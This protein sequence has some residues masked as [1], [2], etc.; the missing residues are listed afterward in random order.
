MLNAIAALNTDDLKENAMQLGKDIVRYFSGFR[1]S[2]FGLT[3]VLASISLLTLQNT[4]AYA[5]P[6]YSRQT[7]LACSS[8]HYTPP[9]LNAFGRQ[10]KAG[11]YTFTTKAAISEDKKDHNAGLNI[12]ENFPLSVMFFTSLTSTNKTVPNN[13][14]SNFQFPQQ[15][16][17]FLAGKWAEHVGS[18]AQV[19]YSGASNNFNWDNTDVRIVGNDAKLLGKTLVYGLTFNNNPTVEDL[20]NSTP[21]WGYPFSG[22]N[23]TPKPAAT[24]IINGPLGQDV[25]GLGGYGLWN[26]HVYVAGTAY[27]SE[28][29]GGNQPNSGTGWTYNIH[30]VAP[31]WRVAW[32][33]ATDKSNVMV[34]TYGMHMRS[35]PNKVTGP[36]DDYTDWAAD[37]QY[38]RKIPQLKN[39][40]VSLRGTYIREKSSLHASFQ[41]G[42]A[43][44]VDHHLNTAQANLEYHFGNRI[45]AVGAFFNTTGTADSLLY[46]QAPVSGSATG[47]PSSTGA[48]GQL[49]YWPSQNVQLTAQYTGYTRFNGTSTNYDGAKRNAS[50]NNATYLQVMFIF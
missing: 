45:N 15:F 22:S 9:E 10:F 14:N 47:R 46:A 7:G 17:I 39:D 1:V 27:R 36:E 44:Q 33:N 24:A 40:V 21:A 31:Y 30:G 28:H 20:W 4:K 26:D 19:T 8:C 42:A 35:S 25:A 3:L 16:G 29:L 50:D 5:V 23:S 43:A 2:V 37:F 38:D 11:G 48:I 32:Q 18:F 6:S 41:N 12:L 49:S 34:G 13:Q